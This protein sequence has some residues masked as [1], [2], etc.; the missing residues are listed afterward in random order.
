MM[1]IG[2]RFYIHNWISFQYTL[3]KNGAS[4]CFQIAMI[5]IFII[6]FDKEY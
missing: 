3:K 4:V 6:W 5:R 2:T 1:D